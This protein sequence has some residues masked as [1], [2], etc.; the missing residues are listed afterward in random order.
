MDIS[1]YLNFSFYDQVWFKD[2]TGSSLFD[3]SQWLVVS[4]RT[5]RD[6]CYHVLNK[7]GNVVSRS[8]VQ[9]VTELKKRTWSTK[10]LFNKFDIMINEKLKVIERV[11]N[12]T[13]R[14]GLST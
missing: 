3:P 2:N 1:E 9:R 5:G 8:T 12:P 11:I 13:L 4:E 10:D 7:N 14:I 6:V